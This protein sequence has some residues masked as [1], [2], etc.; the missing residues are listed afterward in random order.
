MNNRTS[1]SLAS[2]REQL[3]DVSAN[4]HQSMTL[5]PGCYSDDAIFRL[6]TDVIFHQSGVGIGRQNRWIS[7]GDYVAMG[8]VGK[9][10]L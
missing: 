1:F 7:V 3:L 10:F 9:A 2:L 4:H 6:E 5:P 8:I